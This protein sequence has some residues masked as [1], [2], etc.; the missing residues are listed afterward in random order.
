MRKEWNLCGVGDFNLVNNSKLNSSLSD[1]CIKELKGYLR[2]ADA[3]WMQQLQDDTKL[4]V[5]SEDAKNST[6]PAV[7]RRHLQE[8]I[9]KC[10][11]IDYASTSDQLL[12]D[13]IQFGEAINSLDMGARQLLD[14][15]VGKI[16]KHIQVVVTD[17]QKAGVNQRKISVRFNKCLRTLESAYSS[18]LE[19]PQ[20]RLNQNH[21]VHFA[22][23]IA[24]RLKQ[25][26]ITLTC[27]KKGDFVFYLEIILSDIHN[28][29][30]LG[31]HSLAEAALAM[32]FEDN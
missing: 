21:K 15:G 25:L 2:G 16:Y 28:R 22:N 32:G 6:R 1:P 11:A 4:Y 13:I 20:G 12:K 8:A 31:L 17:I 19:F 18:A 10:K 5:W 23:R 30:F 9:L 7:I 3:R 26:N 14:G 29:E 24:L 27:A